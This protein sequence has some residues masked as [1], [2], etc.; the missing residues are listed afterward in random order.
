MEMKI[1]IYTCHMTIKDVL[2]GIS[3]RH[4]Q[5]MEHSDTYP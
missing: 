4:T 1:T 2:D 3:Q 5:S